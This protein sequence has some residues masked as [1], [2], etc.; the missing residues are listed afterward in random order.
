VAAGQATGAVAGQ[1]PGM[2]P[3]QMPP[4]QAWPDGQTLPQRPQLAA[5]FCTL[6]QIS[7]PG[8]KQPFG[9]APPHDSE[10]PPPPHIPPWQITPGG[11]TR[12]QLPQLFGSD[13][14]SVHI[15]PVGPGHILGLSG[16]QVIPP[17]LPHIPAWQ[18]TPAGQTLPQPPQFEGSLPRLVQYGAPGAPQALGCAGGQVGAPP[19][20]PF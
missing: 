16:V 3:L 19:Q 14:V 18:A 10:P 1:V 7:P 15:G 12:P 4:M 5:S 8:P 6:V 20:V 13:I 2:V 11:Q 9:V 17:P